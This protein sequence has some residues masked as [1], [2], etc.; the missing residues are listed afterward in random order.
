MSK[1]DKTETDWTEFLNKRFG[2]MIT[3][4]NNVIYT[5]I[6]TDMTRPIKRYNNGT[7]DPPQV[8][9]TYEHITHS[10]EPLLHDNIP[11][12]VTSKYPYVG[13]DTNPN[14]KGDGYYFPDYQK[15]GVIHNYPEWTPSIKTRGSAPQQRREFPVEI[16]RRLQP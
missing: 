1:K 12:S 2:S 3:R 8:V 5:P 14:Y 7:V 6:V 13:L 15:Y 4:R 10:S 11:S 16:R 9:K